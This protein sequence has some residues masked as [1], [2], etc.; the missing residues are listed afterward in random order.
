MIPLAFLGGALVGAAGLLSVALLDAKETE[1]SFPSSLKNLESLDDEEVT[2]LL[3]D[4]SIAANLLSAKC[5][6][7]EFESVGLHLTSFKKDDDS[8]FQKAANTVYDGLARTGRSM[9][10]NQLGRL[11]DEAVNLYR[12]YHGVFKQ[13]NA[14]L[15]ERGMSPVDLR[16]LRAG[17]RKVSINN[18]IDNDDWYLD[19]DA[20][21]DNIRT[22]LEKSSA[23]A[24]QPIAIFEGRENSSAH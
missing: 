1:S 14:L 4:Y 20:A 19:F 5:N 18:A 15:C 13:A 6:M 24:E 11:K 3:L 16:P 21:A 23:I 2:S 17:V 7:L 9:R 8:L 10:C 22:F 12:R